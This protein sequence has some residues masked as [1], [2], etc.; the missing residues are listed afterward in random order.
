VDDLAFP[1]VA[2]KVL[3]GNIEYHGLADDWA[4][5]ELVLFRESVLS[6]G[7]HDL[8]ALKFSDKDDVGRT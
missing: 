5:S 8:F 1:F 2:D 4:F 3:V 6:E 7:T